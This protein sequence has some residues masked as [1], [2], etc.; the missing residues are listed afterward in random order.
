[1]TGMADAMSKAN[2]DVLVLADGKKNSGDQIKRYKIKRFS[3]WKPYRRRRKA[4]YLR[5][6]KRR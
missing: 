5:K 3:G 4:R 2:K 6:L 1:M